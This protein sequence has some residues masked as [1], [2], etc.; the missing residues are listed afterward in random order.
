MSEKPKNLQSLAVKCAGVMA[1]APLVTTRPKPAV[2]PVGTTH[3]F[4]GE[5]F[6]VGRPGH[7]TDGQWTSAHVPT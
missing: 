3:N 1:V 2:E 4:E 6:E 5:L 7:E